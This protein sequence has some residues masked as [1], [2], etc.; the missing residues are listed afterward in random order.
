MRKTRLCIICGGQSAEHEVSLQS[1]RNVIAAVNRDRFDVVLIG[2]DKTGTWNRYDSTNF[3]RNA[4]DPSSICLANP[5]ATMTLARVDGLGCIVQ[6]GS[7]GEPV[8][9][10]VVF[11]VLHGTF[12]E[13]G[14]IQGMLK[15]VGIACVGCDITSSSVCMDKDIAKRLLQ[16]AG[17]PVA[18]GVAVDACEQRNFDVEHIID[19][20]GLPLFVK[21]ARLG[22]SVGIRKVKNREELNAAVA[23]AFKYDSK[24]LVEECIK[25]REIESSVLGNRDL[26]VSVPG[27][28]ITRNGFYSYE[29]KYVDEEGTQL[30]APA[31]LD[32]ATAERIKEIAAKSFQ[33]LSCKGMARVDCFLTDGG[34][35]VVNEVNSI[36]G[37]TQISM[38][39]RLLQLSGISYPELVEELVRLALE[40]FAQEQALMTDYCS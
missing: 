14:A 19:S 6:L 20:L 11:P 4:N 5:E 18:R 15:M 1:A 7:G 2:I 3:L 10:D 9:V 24:V 31:D 40:R 37:F 36:P 16:H 26:R 33:A 39:P 13:D 25:G 32:E 21:P 35:V 29:A 17:L 22:S 8:P 27:E 23:N 28:I 34:E 12:G 30:C 38:Y